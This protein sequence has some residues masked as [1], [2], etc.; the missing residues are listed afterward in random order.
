[1]E[2]TKKRGIRCVNM[3]G[4]GQPKLHYLAE[5]SSA[6]DS[7]TKILSGKQNW[8]EFITKQFFNNNKKAIPKDML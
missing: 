3:L 7:E 5:A 8:K 6:N 4:S 2:K 1:M